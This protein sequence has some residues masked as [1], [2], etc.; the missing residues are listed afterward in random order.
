[1]WVAADIATERLHISA[2]GRTKL[3]E[4]AFGPL[5]RKSTFFSRR[6]QCL[7][8]SQAR[9]ESHS[10]LEPQRRAGAGEGAWCFQPLYYMEA[11]EQ[12]RNGI[13]LIN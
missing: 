5:V 6:P 1:M 7:L 4:F 2:N 8:K 11:G 10:S 9:R 13:G 12:G 3:G